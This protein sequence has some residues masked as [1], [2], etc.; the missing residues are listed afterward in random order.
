[1]ICNKKGEFLTKTY[2]GANVLQ[3]T[4]VIW[5]GY[6]LFDVLKDLANKGSSQ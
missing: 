3:Y 1:M 4:G 5:K 2:D 6:K